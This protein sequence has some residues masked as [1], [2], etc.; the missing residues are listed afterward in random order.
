M[1]S[2]FDSSGNKR[3]RLQ[4]PSLRRRLKL[5][6]VRRATCPIQVARARVATVPLPQ[7][8]WS[9]LYT[10]SQNPSYDCRRSSSRAKFTAR[11]RMSI[12]IF[13]RCCSSAA[14]RELRLLC[15]TAE[16]KLSS[17]KS[18]CSNAGDQPQLVCSRCLRC[19]HWNSDTHPHPR[20]PQP[21]FCCASA[22]RFC[23][24]CKGC[25]AARRLGG[26]GTPGTKMPGQSA[27]QNQA[28]L[29]LPGQLAPLALEVQQSDQRLWGGQLAPLRRQAQLSDQRPWGQPPASHLLLPGVWVRPQRQSAATRRLPLH[30]PFPPQVHWP[31]A[32]A[33]YTSSHLG[34]STHDD[35]QPHR[36]ARRRN[37]EAAFVEASMCRRTPGWNNAVELPWRPGSAHPQ[38]NPSGAERP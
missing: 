19:A 7:F 13:L 38:P 21:A 2:A 29:A 28:S 12:G 27:L 36:T 30:R 3:F 11:A 15:F 18:C 5:H 26:T 37:H 25:H 14:P 23:R 1:G 16:A 32:A 35:G 4:R 34:P 10:W 22:S 24:S 9:G 6:C 20:R 8:R 31:G 33:W 17:C